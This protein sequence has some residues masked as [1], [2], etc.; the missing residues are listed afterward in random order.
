MPD[1]P[2]VLIVDDS[3]TICLLLQVALAR[4]GF[5]PLV[6]T[7]VDGARNHASALGLHALHLA[8]L[9]VYLEG[10]ADGYRLYEQWRAAC[11]ELPIVLMSGAPKA[12]TLPAVANRRVPLVA[13]PFDLD[14]L[15]PFLV[16]QAKR[17]GHGP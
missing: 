1:P 8:V 17:D 3:D 14:T 4:V 2:T 15:I 5:V 16:T 6:A 7:T 12:S 13:K 9:D 11:P 10:A